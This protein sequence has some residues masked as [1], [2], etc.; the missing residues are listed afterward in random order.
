VAGALSLADGTAAN[1]AQYSFDNS[2]WSAVGGA[3]GVPGPVTAVSVDNLN[4]SSIFAAGRASDGSAPF[5]THWNGAQWSAI[6]KFRSMFIL[7][8]ALTRAQALRSLAPPK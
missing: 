3:S 5:L 7:D 2:T 1:V 8:S 4:S 6:S